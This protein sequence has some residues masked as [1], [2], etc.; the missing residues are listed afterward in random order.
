M[1]YITF[2]L[3]SCSPL[4]SRSETERFFFRSSTDPD[5]VSKE[6][7]P[8]LQQFRK[9]QLDTG[10]LLNVGVCDV[11][12]Q[13]VLHVTVNATYMYPE[14]AERERMSKLDPDLI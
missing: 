3:F 10:H 1:N 14:G 13:A 6:Q 4:H 2:T 5:A 7:W 8:I 11:G 12:T 9:E